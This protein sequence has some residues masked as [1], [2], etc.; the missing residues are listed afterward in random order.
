MGRDQILQVSIN[1]WLKSHQES[2][3]D[4]VDL[5]FFLAQIQCRS[6]GLAVWLRYGRGY[7][8]RDFECIF[9]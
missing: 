1:A 9:V 4:L 2:I 6:G 5:A 3:A 7:S 8:L